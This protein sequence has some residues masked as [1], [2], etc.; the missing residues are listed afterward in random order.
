MASRRSTFSDGT[1]L[2]KAD[3]C[4]SLRTAVTN[5]DLRFFALARKSYPGQLLS[6]EAVP[7]LCSIGYWDARHAQS[8]GLD[9]H[10]NEGIEVTWLESGSL[11]F[12]VNEE[13]YRLSAGK[14]TVTRPWQPH[15]V[16]N[17]N[18]G[19]SKL[20]WLILDV[21]VRRPNQTWQWPDW[22]VLDSED[23]AR[24]TTLIRHNE[25]PVWD[26]TDEMGKCWRA[27]GKI[28][29][30]NPHSPSVS[31]ITILI[32]DICY[33]LLEILEAQVLNLDESLNSSQRTVELFLRD[34]SQSHE[35]AALPWTLQSMAEFCG[36]GTTQ[37]VKICR[38][39]TNQTPTE[40]LAEIRIGYAKTLLKE[41]RIPITE[42][43]FAS[44][45]GSSQYFSFKFKFH[46]GLSPRSFRS[47]FERI[48]DGKPSPN[49]Y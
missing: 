24:L 48:M 12:Y 23:L 10:R 47:K 7:G 17:P 26:S 31:K 9:W 33:N 27:I 36:L 39:I 21:G 38:R 44:G 11:G 32:N 15:R 45:F 19:A 37:F 34:L 3:D 29:E 22:I 30:S 8:W 1:H 46:T 35:H 13:R 4:E 25:H 2:H 41:T 42:V 14:T 49:E 43:A 18:V 40:Y 5:G 16:G 20:F 6:P 28:L